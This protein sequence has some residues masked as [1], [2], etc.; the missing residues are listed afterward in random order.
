MSATRKMTRA[1][2]GG[3]VNRVGRGEI[4]RMGAGAARGFVPPE[5]TTITGLTRE[6]ARAADMKP[7]ASS[8]CST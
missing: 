6:A 4:A 5:R 8:R 2:E 7:L 1:T 3:G